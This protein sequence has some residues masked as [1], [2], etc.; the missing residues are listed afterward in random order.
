[1]YLYKACPWSRLPKF[2]FFPD[3]PVFQSGKCMMFL[4]TLLKYL[5]HDHF[6]HCTHIIFRLSSTTSEF[7]GRYLHPSL[8][9]D[10]QHDNRPEE[11]MGKITDQPFI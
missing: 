11:V 10:A 7:F 2:I 8:P 6:N 4:S 3:Q 1:M 5:Y 9:L